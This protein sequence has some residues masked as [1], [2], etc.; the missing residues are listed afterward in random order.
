MSTTASFELAVIDAMDRERARREAMH[1]LN[2]ECPPAIELADDDVLLEPIASVGARLSLESPQAIIANVLYPGLIHL[3][4]GEPRTLKSITIR[5]M[6]AAVS[7]CRSFGHL[8]RLSVSQPATVAYYTEEDSAAAIFEHL[9]AF[10]AGLAGQGEAPIFVSAGK[11]LSLDDIPTQERILR[12]LSLIEPAVVVFEPL[13]SLSASVDQGPRELQP[14]TA[15]LRR[16][17]RETGAAVVLGHHA[18]KPQINDS[19]KGTQR[20]SGGGL[21]SISECAFEFTR[22][23]EHTCRMTPRGFKHSATP[24]PIELRL[25]TRAGHVDRLVASEFAPPEPVEARVE[26]AVVNVVRAA[27]GLSA[28]AIA[29]RVNLRKTD[30][31]A[32]LHRLASL[33]HLRSEQAGRGTAWHVA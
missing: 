6:V 24:A 31:H 4:Y 22:E 26:T 12:E 15:F 13:R 27:P 2:Q 33:G 20:I 25:E 29:A 17:I 10:T 11:G 9:N 23:D 28:N 16:L 30:V 14:L 21:F 3:M 18:V 8:D 19:R 7:T 32:T 1:R 5:E